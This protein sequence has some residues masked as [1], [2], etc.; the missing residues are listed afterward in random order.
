MTRMHTRLAAI[1]LTI[2][3]LGVVAGGCGED[4]EAQP[5][6]GSAS[7]EPLAGASVTVGSKE[8]TEQL[9]LGQITIQVLEDAGADVTDQTGLE[10]SVAARRALTS[11]EIDMYW[12]YTG[13]AWV[14]YLDNEDPIP[15]EQR[16]FTQVKQEDAANGIEWLD[17]APFNNTYAFA[18][19]S[20]AGA[21]LDQVQTLSD[22]AQ[23]V[24]SNPELAKLC[25][26]E[27]FATRRDG[28]P[29][30][31]REYGFKFP[32]DQVSLVG[33]AVVYDQVASGDRCN[34][35]SVFSSDGKIKANDLRVLEDDKRFFPF[36]NP[37]LTVRE[38]VLTE[39]PELAELF[40]PVSE[41]LTTDVI[42]GLNARVD[43]E[44]ETP[45]DVAESFLSDNGLVG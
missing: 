5:Q 30:V 16:Q 17:P 29:G 38:Q 26:G 9:I 10:G 43:V 21:E 20:N 18:V 4:D 31:E 45:E 6:G 15:D 33:D 24:Q 12:E 32:D 22:L 2:G 37:A 25:V 7:Q 40:T 27:E 19:R 11:G 1:A 3:A 36:F 14:N 41:A 13:T 39:H 28:L 8:F 23:L 35:G 34:F 42:S 44:G